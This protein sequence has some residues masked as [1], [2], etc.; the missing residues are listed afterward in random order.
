M[1][2]EKI[3]IYSAFIL[4]IL[5]LVVVFTNNVYADCSDIAGRQYAPYD[6]GIDGPYVDNG[7]GT[8]TDQRTQLMWQK[9]SGE[10][11]VRGGIPITYTWEEACQ[12]CDDLVLADYDD[13]ELPDIS[14]LRTLINSEFKPA[15][16]LEFFPDTSS[17]NYFY[18]T[19]SSYSLRETYVWYVQF[20]DGGNASLSA[21]DDS[22]NIRCVRNRGHEQLIISVAAELSEGSAPLTNRFQCDVESGNPPYEFSWDFGD[23][24]SS[25]EQNPEHTYQSAGTY[26]AKVTVIDDTGLASSG[27]V[28]T[29][30]V[31]YV[32]ELVIAVEPFQ[33]S[34]TAPLDI[35]FSCVVESGNPPYEFSWDF[36]DGT[37][38][39]EQNPEHT[40][41]SGGYSYIATVVVTDDR[42]LTRSAQVFIA[43]E[44]GLN[45]LIIKAEASPS[46][47]TAPLDISFSCVVESGNPPYEFSWD[48]G[49]GTSSNEQNPE[50]TYESGG[51]SYIATV[52]VTDDRSLTRSAQVFI[53]VEEGLND[54][55]IKAEASPSSG[56]APL[57]ISFSCVV[58]SGNPPYE[59]SWDFGDGTSSNEQNP[60]HT[61]ESG[62]YSYIAT[63]VVT[64]DRSLTRSA[65]VFI[66]VEEGL[67]D[68]IIKAEA[69]P[70]S[71]TAPLDISF[72]CVVESGNP[73]YEF[74]WDFG[75]G[76]SSN[77][78]NPEHTY[79]SGGYSY[80]A[81]VVVTDDRSLTR[82]AQVF[83]AV[84]EGLNDLIIKAEAS[85]SSGTAPLDISFSC[86]VESGNPPYEFSWTFGDGTPLSD[87]EDPEHT[88]ES[89]GT[90][91]A[92]VTVTDSEGLTRSAE[93]DTVVE[94]KLNDLI[95]KAEASPSSGTAP[96]DILFSCEV[97]SGNPPYEFSW[98]FGDGTP[99]SDEEDPEHTYESAGTYT[100]KVTVTDSE[101]LT[102][103]AEMDTVVEE[104]LNDL[105]IKAEAS[106]SSGTA[107][108]DILF[109]C[110]VESGNPPYEFTWDFGEGTSSNEQNPAHTY[111]YTGDYKATVVV[112]D[113]AQQSQKQDLI[114]S[115]S[116]GFQEFCHV[117]GFIFDALTGAGISRAQLLFNAPDAKKVYLTDDSGYFDITDIPAGTYKVLI[118]KLNYHNQTFESIIL[119]LGNSLDLTTSLDPKA[120]EIVKAEAQS[121]EITNNNDADAEFSVEVAH[122]DSL[123]KI[124]SVVLNLLGLNFSSKKLEMSPV[125]SDSGRYQ[126]IVTIPG[127]TSA[128]HYSIPVTVE[129][130]L[131]YKDYGTID[132]EVSRKTI[133]SIEPTQALSQS[134]VNMI[135]TQTIVI[136]IEV[137]KSAGQKINAEKL[138]ATED[139]YV[140]VNVYRPDGTFY[141]DYEVYD[142]KEITITDAEEGTWTYETINYCAESV[143][144]EIETRGANTGII[145]GTVR[146]SATGEGIENASVSWSLG[147]IED[148]SE[149]TSANGYFSIVAVAGTSALVSSAENYKINIRTDVSLSSGKT[150]TVAVKL[151]PDVSE[152]LPVPDT[153]STEQILTPAQSPDPVIQPFTASI[154]DDEFIISTLF[155]PYETPVNI[156]LGL[157]LDFPELSSYI[158]LFNS[159]DQ[160]DVYLDTLFPWRENTTE[161]NQTE[162]LSLPVSVLPK[163]NYIFYF[164]IT[165]DP[166]ALSTYD[167]KFFSLKID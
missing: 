59:F 60:E 49:D 100:A 161:W 120:P 134:I 124:K 122:P 11:S 127:D 103:S 119:T 88:Y 113:H 23:G 47:G 135:R 86:V 3:N 145:T 40:Y 15:I 70:S 32:Q 136:Y 148:G 16:N 85:P 132:L 44:E 20:Q 163:G 26:T 153:Q 57:D 36:G 66:A 37:S 109:S 45:D 89:A 84:E 137:A 28:V 154:I 76:T 151:V 143:D 41:E 7:D 13:W 133:D 63:V 8:I 142:S 54:L 55:I 79:E 116:Q 107:P 155:A 43:V 111:K 121:V 93:M 104:E 6:D 158:F 39:N 30:V 106:P 92:K 138:S 78:Q 38:S 77:E 9:S 141:D 139:C 24:T 102:R 90:Y 94:E 48:F 98:T 164:L 73:P 19:G 112:T 149:L 68:L 50:H 108:L 114:I 21:K 2:Q 34:G 157:S 110:E 97:E 17:S 42:S 72:S 64:D 130:T 62:G 128:R 25:N 1:L 129:D 131:G 22:K 56:T 144:V 126:A 99:L 35:S 51:Y 118:S 27:E 91:T 67:N 95:I 123:T 31:G 61:Y 166:I 96:L 101:G 165:D 140:L 150:T 125:D 160:F 117:K 159:N 82:S 10:V 162:L 65:Q 167:L 29:E 74:S 156:Y 5:F 81:T 58:E 80:I 75:D 18:W 4:L 105:I 69:S 46:S 115:V 12:Y 52:V 152:P 83:I 87:E 147:G 33:T 71:G 14:Q 146:D 53:A